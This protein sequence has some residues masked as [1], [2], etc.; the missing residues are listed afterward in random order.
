MKPQPQIW[1]LTGLIELSNATVAT[2]VIR[3]PAVSV[4][5]S[6]VILAL[7]GVPIGGNVTVGTE[8]KVTCDAKWPDASVWAA[9]YQLINTR[10]ALQIAQDASPIN[11]MMLVP[12]FTYAPGQ[13]LGG[14]DETMNAL[15]LEVLPVEDVDEEEEEALHVD[16][17]DGEYWNV[18]LSAEVEGEKLGKF[19]D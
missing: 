10:R 7:A 16:S 6:S 5:I 14:K 13:V 3:N 1:C 9:Q 8:T 12:D 11:Y 17:F 2:V 18:Y 4:G 15:Q 19:R